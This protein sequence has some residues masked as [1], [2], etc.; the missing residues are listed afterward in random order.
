[1]TEKFQIL[2][3]EGL[4]SHEPEVCLLGVVQ[5]PRQEGLSPEDLE[6]ISSSLVIAG[7]SARS[8]YSSV[9]LKPEAYL[10]P[11]H[12][13]ITDA[14]VRST[15]ESGHLT[16]RQHVHYV[17]G[18]ERV[19]RA[20]IWCLHGHP[21]YNSD[22]QSQRYV[23]MKAGNNL[24]PNLSEEALEVY[25]DTVERQMAA[26]FD[27]VK[28]LTPMAEEEYFQRFPARRKG[29]EAYAGEIQKKAQEVA[30]YV[31]PIATHTELYHTVSAL[32]LMRYVRAAKFYDVPT[33]MTM[34]VNKMVA[35]VVK[36]DPRFAEELQDPI[37]LEETPEFI[38]LRDMRGE[39][40]FQMARGFVSEF[41]EL[42]NGK[43]SRL[44]DYTAAGE[45]TIANAARSLLG[46]PRARLSD[47]EAIALVLDPAKNKLLGEPLNL[48]TMSK[49]SRA[50]ELSSYTVAKRLSH[51]ADS[52]DQRHRMVPAARPIL[53]AQYTGEPDYI[54]PK[55][56]DASSE[57]KEV[58]QQIMEETFG[59]INCLL[60][61]GVS[62]EKA[63]YLLPNA[64]SIRFFE[65]GSLLN[66]H[67]KARMR[68]CF[69]A[70]E[71]IWQAA[72]EEAKQISKVHPLIGERLLAPCDIR[73][74]AGTV[75]Y[76]PEGTRYCGV[77]VWNLGKKEYHRL[78]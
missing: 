53:A 33:E 47:S 64:F 66:L 18:L 68:L 12:Q 55:L 22:Q 36:V 74:Q 5:A 25:N 52:Q 10:R 67:H 51:T 29:A 72:V 17:F 4:L 32:T 48:T 40:N 35:E 42:L 7:E 37:P 34:I 60:K 75:P 57:A 46:L 24:I 38:A 28:K 14:V 31:L 71:E 54:K 70:Q 45:A 16:T 27:L 77:P 41:D 43:N 30:R 73:K 61:S 13:K 15:R 23:E 56:I 58:Y 49:L 59:A 50:M 62:W 6:K 2:S 3:I 8:C 1:M 44:V 65:S 11:S 9:L 39:V 78:I 76:C 69:T 26:Y 63:S 19:S 21:F 20:V